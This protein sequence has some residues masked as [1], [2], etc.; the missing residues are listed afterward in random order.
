MLTVLNATDT[1]A[2]LIWAAGDGRAFIANRDETNT[3]ITGQTNGISSADNAHDILDP[4]GGFVADGSVNVYARALSGKNVIIDAIPG[5]MFW[6]PSPVQAAVQIAELGLATE[7]NQTTQIGVAGNTNTI[8]GS[9]AQDGTVSLVNTTLGAPAQDGSVIALP[10]GI[11]ATGVPLYSKPSVFASRSNLSVPAASTRTIGPGTVGQIGYEVGF[12]VSGSASGHP[13]VTVTMTWVDSVTGLLV[14]EEIWVLPA[15]SVNGL[16][17][18]GTG[19]TKG[20]T[21]TVSIANNDPTTALTVS[22]VI[23]TNSRL[24]TRDDWRQQ[25][26]DT[27]IGFTNPN[28]DQ[29]MNLLAFTQPTIAAGNNITRLLPLY[30]GRVFI[31]AQSNNAPG[32]VTISALDPNFPTVTPPIYENTIGNGLGNGINA[33]IDLPRCPCTIFLSNTG[34][35]SSIF[36]ATVTIEEYLP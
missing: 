9:P 20:D 23:A 2:A 26:I 21:L 24:Y 19:P 27:V 1:D 36:Q 28:A 25:N 31:T 15:G 18:Y 35:G 3:V 10:G 13:F 5:A 14:A 11:F 29:L 12:T 32:V 30:A 16:T 7:A 4:L 17:Y 6:A 34:T 8:L 33:G 22:C